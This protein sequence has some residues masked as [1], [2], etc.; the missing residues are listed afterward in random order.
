MVVV[1]RKDYIEMVT[2]L[3]AQTM[4]RTNNR[5]PTNKLKAKLSISTCMPWD[6]LLIFIKLT[7]PQA[8]CI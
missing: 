1:D 7:P 2:N 4:Y 6:A 3:L 8:Y 5:D